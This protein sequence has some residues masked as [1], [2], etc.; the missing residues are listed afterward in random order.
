MVSLKFAALLPQLSNLSV[1][2][3]INAA[4]CQTIDLKAT[5]TKCAS[6]PRSPPDS[7]LDERHLC[8]SLDACRALGLAEAEIARL[9]PA[10]I[11][12]PLW[13]HDVCVLALARRLA[14]PVVGTCRNS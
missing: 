9:Q 13:L 7:W 5:P 8:S 10:V 3:S 14:V 11:I 6:V 4:L 1:Y 2:S 12:V